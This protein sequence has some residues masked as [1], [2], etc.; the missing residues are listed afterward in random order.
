MFCRLTEFQ[1]MLHLTDPTQSPTEETA[2]LKETT[3]GQSSEAELAWL[4]WGCQPDSH[5]TPQKEN[6]D[7]FIRKENG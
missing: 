4:L 7:D 5:P 1:I 2:K 6:K 3:T